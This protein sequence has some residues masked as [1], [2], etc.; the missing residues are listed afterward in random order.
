[1]PAS[2][3][4][5]V[6]RHR[7]VVLVEAASWRRLLPGA[8]ALARRAARAA[9]AAAGPTRT[10]ELAIVLVDDADQR[11]LNLQW[12]GKDKPTNV[13]AFP[14]SG[15]DAAAIP[16]GA[17]LPLGDVVLAAETVAREAA[18]QS[19]P[20]A[21]HLTHLVIHGMLHLLGHDHDRPAAARRMEALETRLLAQLGIRDPYRP[22]RR[23]A[24]PRTPARA[25]A[26]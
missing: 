22:Q 18:A 1:M 19:K 14:G 26:R 12:R 3:P 15:T 2:P 9:L 23:A 21:D 10:A 5:P 25:G 11:A 4:E 6:R 24:A 8:P 13:L 17:P 16:A 20:L 7:I